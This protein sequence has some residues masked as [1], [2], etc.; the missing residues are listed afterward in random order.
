[1]LHMIEFA[2]IPPWEIH[3]GYNA[4]RRYSYQLRCGARHLI[5]RHTATYSREGYGVNFIAVDR[6][7]PDVDGYPIPLCTR[8]HRYE[9]L[10]MPYV[11]ERQT[12]A[13]VVAQLPQKYRTVAYLVDKK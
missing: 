11:S 12:L 5:M 2:Y 3:D 13:T 9:L 4:T 1:M 6:I 8:F 7:M 10:H